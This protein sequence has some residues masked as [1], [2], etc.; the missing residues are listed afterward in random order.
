MNKTETTTTQTARA[1]QNRVTLV[2]F[3]GNTPEKRE[4]RAVL[5]LATKTSW[6]PKDSQDWK[7]RTEWHRVTVWGKLAEAVA[8]FVKGEHPPR[9]RRTAE[10]RVRARSRHR[11]EDR[12]GQSPELGSPRPQRAQAVR[13]PKAA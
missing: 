8:T 4:G 9:R 3:I 7:S 2:G 6:Q 10:Q 11:Q 13:Q 12:Q 1:Y 5:S